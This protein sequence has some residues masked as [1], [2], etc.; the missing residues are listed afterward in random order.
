MYLHVFIQAR[1]DP[2]FIHVPC[3]ALTPSLFSRHGFIF[4]FP[5]PLLLASPRYRSPP[6]AVME[7]PR[8]V[9]I[10]VR[11]GSK[12]A[13][14]LPREL[15]PLLIWGVRACPGGDDGRDG[16][17]RQARPPCLITGSTNHWTNPRPYQP[18]TV[19]W[20]AT[21]HVSVHAHGISVHARTYT[22]VK[23]P[24]E[25]ISILLRLHTHTHMCERVQMPAHGSAQ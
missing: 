16:T 20:T 12:P 7:N 15:L 4:L 6:L 23:Q 14:L 17:Q 25:S 9:Q 2:P 5:L 1:L 21:A 18:A 19:H 24:P 10:M 3:G 13:P 11:R 22:R 8:P